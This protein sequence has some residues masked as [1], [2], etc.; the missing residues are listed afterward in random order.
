M[1]NIC[2]VRTWRFFFVSFLVYS[3]I[4]YF[5]KPLQLPHY[6]GVPS[7]K[8]CAEVGALIQRLTKYLL[9]T[10]TTTTYYFFLLFFA[11][12][13]YSLL[14]WK[15]LFI[16]CFGSSISYL[17][18][19]TLKALRLCIHVYSFS[20]FFLL[21]SSR[22]WTSSPLWRHLKSVQINFINDLNKI[23]RKNFMLKKVNDK[24]MTKT[25]TKKK[26]KK[27]RTIVLVFPRK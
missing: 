11:L 7:G 6:S 24:W 25:T 15:Y 3:G 23:I 27:K 1:K 4:K 10:T 18:H 2:F 17:L 9:T 14:I 13:S 12:W 8:S 22:E 16:E 19:Y 5:F 26:K 20:Y 21:V